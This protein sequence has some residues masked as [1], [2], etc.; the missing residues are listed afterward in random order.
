MSEEKKLSV[1]KFDINDPKVIENEVKLWVE[2]NTTFK[3]G[4]DLINSKIKVLTPIKNDE[5]MKG[6]V[7]LKAENV[8]YEKSSLKNAKKLKDIL[9]AARRPILEFE[10]KVFGYT[11]S[12]RDT[13][14]KLLSDWSA[15]KEAEYQAKLAAQ[16]A[17]EAAKEAAR[18]KEIEAQKAAG[19]QEPIIETH[20]V[21]EEIITPPT[22]ITGLKTR[23]EWSIVLDEEF[24][25]KVPSVLVD[26][27]K[28]PVVILNPDIM[29][30]VKRI[31]RDTGEVLSIPNLTIT[32]K[33][34]KGF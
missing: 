30:I 9:N 5:E 15:I 28:V 31:Y 21:V 16:R 33:E 12:N 23:T 27:Q 4:S 10:K 18:Q 6:I 26:G 29:T 17:E 22:K 7:A 3:G 25:T 8:E 32:K 13:L 11:K 34:V 24:K 2:N 1:I 14:L 19:V 20:E